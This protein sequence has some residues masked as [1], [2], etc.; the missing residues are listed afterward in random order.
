MEYIKQEDLKDFHF[1]QVPR[2]IWKAKIKG[3]LKH[4]TQMNSIRIQLLKILL[5]VCNQLQFIYN[6]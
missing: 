1:L 6:H 4:A 2:I 5:N 3:Q